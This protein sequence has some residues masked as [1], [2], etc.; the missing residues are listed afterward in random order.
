MAISYFPFDT[1][2]GASIQE[3]QWSKMAQHW[4]GTGVLKTIMNELLVY[5]DSTG[6]QVKVKSGAAYIKGHYYDNDSETTLGIGNSTTLPRIDRVILRCDWTLN[7]IQLAVI[8]GTPTL[9]PVAPPLTQNTSR[10]E[11]SLAQIAVGANVATISAA[12]VTDERDFGNAQNVLWSGSSYLSSGA[13]VSPTKKLSQCRN[14]W[15]LVWSDYDPGVGSN[16]W[17]FAHSF[18]S[19]KSVELK[20]GCTHYF[21]I[22]CNLTTSAVTLVGKQVRIYDDR[23]EGQ[24]INDPSTGSPSSGDVCLRYIIEM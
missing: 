3:N 19:K 12:S 13:V 16:D 14:G 5:A 7:N 15:I 20:N 6:M 2:P 11:I 24:P 1:G 22:I 10:W 17:D 18:V 4:L 9:S 21:P 8:Q 23:I